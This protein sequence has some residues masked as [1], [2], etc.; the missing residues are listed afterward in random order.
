MTSWTPVETTVRI[1]RSQIGT[2]MIATAFVALYCAWLVSL[3]NWEWRRSVMDQQ[4]DIT[5]SIMG[6]A[7]QI[8]DAGP[9]TWRMWRMQIESDCDTDT[10]HHW[11]EKFDAWLTRGGREE[12]MIHVTVSGENG[13]FSIAPILVEM[14]AAPLNGLWLEQLLR[15][16]R[17]KGWGYKIV[18]A[19]DS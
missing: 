14:H 5:H 9:S 7:T 15:A 12:P 8:F 2:L 13:R 1:R 6:G 16:Y 17:E 19:P 18:E 3:R 11:T 4:R 10:R